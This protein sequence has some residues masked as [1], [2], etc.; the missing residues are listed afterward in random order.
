MIPKIYNPED[1]PMKTPIIKLAKG[2]GNCPAL[3]AVDEKGKTICTLQVFVNGKVL[4]I[5]GSQRTL[6]YNG[7][8]TSFCKWSDLGAMLVFPDREDGS[9]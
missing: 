5:T 4:A 3:I 6:A 2:V 1:P 9:L 7:Y 8:D